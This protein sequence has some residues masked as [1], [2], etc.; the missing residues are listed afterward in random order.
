MNM[1]RRAMRR[2]VDRLEEFANNLQ[3]GHR[4]DAETVLDSG[5]ENTS[6]SLN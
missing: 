2:A 3:S 1:Q 5:S 6:K 4:S